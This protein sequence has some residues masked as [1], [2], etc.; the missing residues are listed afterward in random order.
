M[1]VRELTEAEIEALVGARHEV[2]GLAYPAN[3]LQPYYAWLVRTLHLLAESSAGALRVARDAESA[4]AVRVMPGRATVDGVVVAYEGG[5]LDL[6]LHNNDTA[7]VWLVEDAEQ[8]KVEAGAS[9]DGWPVG[10]H[11]KLAE[12]ELAEGAIVNVLDRRF[13]TML[14]V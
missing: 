11:I 6:A 4:T 7:L 13:E 9:G 2:T 12:V 8:A 3:G 14:K 1:V 5:E 10:P